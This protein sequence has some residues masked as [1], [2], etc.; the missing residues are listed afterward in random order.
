M[1][2]KLVNLLFKNYMPKIHA[3][4]TEREERN[5]Q[6]YALGVESGEAINQLTADFKKFEDRQYQVF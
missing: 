3:F 4:V 1:I 2:K 5:K 6:L